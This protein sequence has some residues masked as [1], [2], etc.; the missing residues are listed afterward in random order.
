M[1]DIVRRTQVCLDDDLWAVLQGR[2][3]AEETTISELVRL[4]VRE[5]YLTRRDE[6]RQ[7]MQAFAG[8]RKRSG[9]QDSAEYI[10]KLR[11]GDRADRLQ[12]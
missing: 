4:A 12:R 3:R 7:A 2:A 9:P 5:R 10:R 8:I 6:R 11:R 1:M